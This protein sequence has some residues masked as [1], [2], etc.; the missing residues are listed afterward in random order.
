MQLLIKYP[1]VAPASSVMCETGFSHLSLVKDQHK[2]S[3][4]EENLNAKMYIKLNGPSQDVFES[5]F[6]AKVRDT[7]LDTEGGR[8]ISI[9]KLPV[10]SVFSKLPEN[11]QQ[12][13]RTGT[14]LK[15]KERKEAAIQLTVVEERGAPM[16]WSLATGRWGNAGGSKRKTKEYAAGKN[17]STKRNVMMPDLTP[18]APIPYLSIFDDHELQLNGDSDHELNGD[19]DHAMSIDDHA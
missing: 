5:L 17:S 19:S 4:V 9:G 1:G 11:I 2:T 16:H 15:E 3:L 12:M 7:W 8:Q 13:I 18:R 14:S 6:L 10:N